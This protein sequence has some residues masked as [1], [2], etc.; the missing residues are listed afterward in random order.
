MRTVAHRGAGPRP[1]LWAG[2]FAVPMVGFGRRARTATWRSAIKL[3]T[4]P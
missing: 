4:A 2:V 1:A 3:A